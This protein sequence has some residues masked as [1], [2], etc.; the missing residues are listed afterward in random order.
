MVYGVWADTNAL[1]S[2]GEASYYLAHECFPDDGLSG[3]LGHD[4]AG[5]SILSLDRT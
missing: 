5:K 4:P 3:N 1:G 2:M